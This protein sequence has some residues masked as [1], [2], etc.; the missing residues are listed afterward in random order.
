[1]YDM[2]LY[3]ILM[4]VFAVGMTVL[5]AFLGKKHGAKPAGMLLYGVIGITYGA[6]LLLERTDDPGKRKTVLA[7]A[8]LI[9]VGLLLYFKYFRFLM[10]GLAS[11]V[12]LLGGSGQWK[13]WDVLLPIGISFYTFQAMS[14]VID[15][16]RGQK[17]ER[18]FGYY[19]LYI[20]FFP[21][22]VA[23]PYS[24]GRDLS[25][26]CAGYISHRRGCRICGRNSLGGGGRYARGREGM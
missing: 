5:A 24:A 20:S 26:Q 8:L 17:A 16:Y 4:A 19:A 12:R 18:H 11:L 2:T 6:G 25:G 14:Y 22:L 15:V 3:A 7:A 13:L 9:P 1:M 23:G 21:Q 10:D